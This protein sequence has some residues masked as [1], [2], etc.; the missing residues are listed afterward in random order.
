MSRIAQLSAA[1]AVVLMPSLAFAHTGVGSV[2]GFA[3]GFLHPFTGIDHL[4]VMIAVGIYAAQ[5]G[6]RALWAVPSSFVALMGVGGALGAMA[7]GLPFVEIAIAISMVALV[8]VIA[9]RVQLPTVIAAALA[10]LFA[11]FHGHAHGAEMPQAADALGY[12]LGFV[13][14]TA[15]LHAVG[16]AIGQMRERIAA[17]L[18]A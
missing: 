8:A 17:R 14:A 1:A 6:G 4:V 9:L 10:G 16:I 2:A 3:A 11:I 12:G 18:S 7:I 15:A 13:V 5:L